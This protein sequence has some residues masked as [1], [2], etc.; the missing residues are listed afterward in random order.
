MG[1]R[2]RVAEA[3][4]AYL[5]GE[6]LG[7][8][9]FGVVWAAQH[10]QMGRRVAIK[11]L[12]ATD[13]G[14]RARF[15]AEARVLASLD[16]P[17]VVPLYD[18]VEADDLCLLVME[19]LEGGTLGSRFFSPHKVD[20]A[21]ACAV[22]MVT[23]AG[24]HHAHLRGVL[25][26]DVKPENLLFSS[27]DVLKVTDFGIAKVMGQGATPSSSTIGGLKGTPAYMAPEQ[28]SG[29]TAGPGVDIYATG[30]LLYE[31]LSAR[32]PFSERGTPVSIA[33]RHITE[34]PEAL[35]VV[36]PDLAGPLA[37]VTMRAL[38]RDPA[39]RFVSAEHFGVAIGEAA[40]RVLGAGWIDES[41][42]RLLTSGRILDS[43][44]LPA[45][46]AATRVATDRAVIVRPGR[47][48]EV[49]TE[50]SGP[51][52]PAFV[53]SHEPGEPSRPTGLTQSLDRPSVDRVGPRRVPV[54]ALAVVM[55]IIL[56]AGGATAAVRLSGSP[57]RHPTPPPPGPFV[58]H[59]PPASAP[60]TVAA[61][62]PPSVVPPV[63]PTATP[64]RN[65]Y[66]GYEIQ[67]PPYVYANPNSTVLGPCEA[68]DSHLLKAGDDLASN[69]AVS[70]PIAFFRFAGTLDEV[71]KRDGNYAPPI[72]QRTT[73]VAGQHA[74]VT[75]GVMSV[76][77]YGFATGARRYTYYVET[78]PTVLVGELLI[79]PQ[80]SASGSQFLKKLFDGVMSSLQFIPS[81]C[82]NLHQIKC[83]EFYWTGDVSKHPVTV[84]V[85]STPAIPHVGDTVTFT[86]TASSPDDDVL[87]CNP[88]FGDEPT[89]STTA[90]P[91]TDG[92][93]GYVIEELRD[94]SNPIGPYGGWAPPTRVAGTKTFTFTHV[95]KNPG[96]YVAGA[97]C[98][99][100]SSASRADGD[101]YDPYFA[102]GSGHTSV[103]VS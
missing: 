56:V 58:T 63:A 95:Y 39:D 33:L 19:R 60:A 79:A 85:G 32:L 81:V 82:S 11:Q 88:F 80:M 36:A 64:C 46:S 22:A 24:L 21:S 15:L 83:G 48:T 5:L 50:A 99:G 18:Y 67:V 102:A 12:S 52:E 51:T 69:G 92:G 74:I 1:D 86:V 73:V 14:V 57:T 91:L 61:T 38:S 89:R 40:S 42:V 66:L 2:D 41:K 98:S 31:L 76:K 71:L 100:S 47:V 45:R 96:A 93:P 30:V 97:D 8:G 16:H 28:V 70:S 13:P 77:E 37:D 3:V 55:A 68:L 25:H 34:E 78:P 6:E 7:R 27:D 43:A 75:D 20:I 54:V 62:T 29:E 103:T 65:V 17:H 101:P 23:C 72:T 84:A 59:A 10:R 49:E 4:P 9:A 90:L 26:R 53:P 44:H 35:D 94:R 87:T